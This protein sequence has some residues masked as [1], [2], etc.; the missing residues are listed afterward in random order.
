MTN[1][2][3][4]RRKTFVDEQFPTY[5]GSSRRRH[6]GI[7]DLVKV[8]AGRSVA[9]ESETSQSQSTGIII[10]RVGVFNELLCQH[11]SSRKA[12]QRSQGLGQERLCLQQCR[13]SS[14]K[15]SHGEIVLYDKD[16]K[17]KKERKY[18]K[19]ISELTGGV[20]NVALVWKYTPC[21]PLDKASWYL[22]ILCMVSG[23][24]I[25]EFHVRGIM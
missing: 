5:R 22:F 7:Q 2:N 18:L 17:R 9:K 8:V 4:I 19:K 16:T 25:Q 23:R 1:R 20:N 3:I 12:R 14:P 13:V 21:I 15:C 6:F 10:R 24:S 11:I